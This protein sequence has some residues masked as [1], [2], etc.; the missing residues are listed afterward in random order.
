MFLETQTE[1]ETQAV[2]YILEDIN[3]ITSMHVV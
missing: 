3:I 1:I 2:L